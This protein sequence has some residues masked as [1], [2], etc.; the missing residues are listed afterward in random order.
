[1]A[2]TEAVVQAEEEKRIGEALLVIN[3]HARSIVGSRRADE[4]A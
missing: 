3:R 4:K 1:V 2:A